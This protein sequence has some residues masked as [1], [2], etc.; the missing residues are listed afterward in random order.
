MNL[1]QHPLL[2]H[3]QH[4]LPIEV[5]LIRAAAPEDQGHAAAPEPCE[6]QQAPVTRVATRGPAE[7]GNRPEF[8]FHA[9]SYP[10]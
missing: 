9:H 5:V 8:S 7:P 4:L 1:M 10:S 6:T 2:G 3:L